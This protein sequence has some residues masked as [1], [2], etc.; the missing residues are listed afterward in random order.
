MDAPSAA[1]LWAF[2]SVIATA[3]AAAVAPPTAAE[4]SAV[5]PAAAVSVALT[6]KAPPEVIETVDGRVASAPALE[7]VT[8]IAAATEIVPDEVEA[9]GVAVEPEPEPPLE[10]A[11][12]LALDRSPATCPSTPPKGAPG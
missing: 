8:V 5:E 6:V 1:L 10:D 7:I 12:V 9:D 2:A 3:A 4:P 11:A